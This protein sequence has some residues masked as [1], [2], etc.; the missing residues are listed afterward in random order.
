MTQASSPEVTR[1][2]GKQML[3]TDEEP[4]RPL[5]RMLRMQWRR[6]AKEL[7]HPVELL[8]EEKAIPEGR[9]G[10]KELMAALTKELES[11]ECCWYLLL[12]QGVAGDPWTRLL[13]RESRC[14]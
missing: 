5:T 9:G 10:V 1:M 3:K 12:T 2:S 4:S 14:C 13:T 11:S 6:M 8:K 7:M